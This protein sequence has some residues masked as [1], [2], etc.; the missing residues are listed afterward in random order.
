M[1]MEYINTDIEGVVILKPQ[2]YGDKRGYFMETYRHSDFCAHIG[3]IDFV[4]DNES[5]STRH[6]VRGLHFQLEPHSQGKLVRCTR[7]CVVDVAV[8]L[9]KGSPTFG[10]HVAIRLDAESGTQLFIPRGFAHGYATLSDVATFQYKCDAYYNPQA[11]SGIHPFD[12][13]LGI[14]WGV[15]PDQAILSDK[16]SARLPLADMLNII[17]FPANPYDRI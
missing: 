14:D 9:R 5:S 1:T 2:I 15:E 8:D 7:G 4:Q 17:N 16:D 10:R 3:N 6:V 11:E 12:P 13:A